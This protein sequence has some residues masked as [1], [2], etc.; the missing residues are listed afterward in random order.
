[1]SNKQKFNFTIKPKSSMDKLISTLEGVVIFLTAVYLYL[2]GYQ[3]NW[4]IALGIFGFL[5]LV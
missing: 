4:I 2:S 1:M 3:N 5:K